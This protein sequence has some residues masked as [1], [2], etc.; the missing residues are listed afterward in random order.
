[1]NIVLKTECLLFTKNE[2]IKCYI[3]IALILYLF[4]I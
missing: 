3:F 4:N 2:E 1:M